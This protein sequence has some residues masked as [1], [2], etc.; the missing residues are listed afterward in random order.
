MPPPTEPLTEQR[1]SGTDYSVDID[2]DDN[3]DDN[4]DDDG[5]I[6]GLLERPGAQM[7]CFQMN[8]RL[9]FK[10]FEKALV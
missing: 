9:A 10:T 8:S 3:D 4:D 5:F 6:W 7:C 1:S 2:D